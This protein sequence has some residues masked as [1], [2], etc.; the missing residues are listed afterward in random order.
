[1]SGDHP[2]RGRYRSGLD[3]LEALADSC[4][5]HL[6]DHGIDPDLAAA[7]AWR[8]IDAARREFGGELIYFPKGRAVGLTDRDARIWAE[9]RGNNH[10]ELLARYGISLRT[11][12]RIIRLSSST[13]R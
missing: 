7:S 10:A 2:G 12:Q 9:F 3:L 13:S 6:C 5:R 1:M 4:A 11:L 8:A